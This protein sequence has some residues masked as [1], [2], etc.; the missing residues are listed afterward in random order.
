MQGVDRHDPDGLL[1]QAP[2][3]EGGARAEAPPPPA[4]RREREDGQVAVHSAVRRT[5]LRD[6]EA[7]CRGKLTGH[8][9][10]LYTDLQTHEPQFLPLCMRVK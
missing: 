1:Q 6:Q 4:D 10:S 9:F 2:T 7:P 3:A 5:H 8:T